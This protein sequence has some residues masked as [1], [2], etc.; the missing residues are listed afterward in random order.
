MFATLSV[1]ESPV[2]LGADLPDARVA[3]VR[4]NSEVG[5][6]YISAGIL[7]LRVVED[8]EKFNSQIERIILVDYRSLREAE[9]GVVEAWAVEETPTGGAKGTQGAVLDESPC[10]HHARVRIGG[11][12]Q[13]GRNEIA[14]RMTI[15]RTIGIGVPRIQN[16]YLPDEIG[17]VRRRAAGQRSIALALVH[18]NGKAGREAGDPLHL[19]PLSKALGPFGESAVEG[20]SPNVAGHEIVPNVGR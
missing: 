18:L 7:E 2:K 4:H 5:I 13:L 12:G 1:A 9:V 8:V 10:G 11:R 15:S 6:A 14:S 20:D 3:R 16:H 19:P 17:H